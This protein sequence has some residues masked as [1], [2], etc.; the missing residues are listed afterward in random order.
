MKYGAAAV[1]W[2]AV[3]VKESQH[4]KNEGDRDGEWRHLGSGD[5]CAK[6]WEQIERYAYMG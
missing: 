4:V 2:A 3:G 5:G 1:R 6:K